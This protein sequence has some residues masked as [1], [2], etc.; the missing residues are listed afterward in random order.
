MAIRI[1]KNMKDSEE[2]RRTDGLQTNSLRLV[3]Q[4]DVTETLIT[5]CNTLVSSV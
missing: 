5:T 4:T 2:T 1:L 3:S